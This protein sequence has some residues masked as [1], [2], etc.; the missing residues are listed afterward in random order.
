MKFEF[1]KYTEVTDL[2]FEI[3]PQY[4]SDKYIRFFICPDVFDT[5]FVRILKG[6]DKNYEINEC[7]YLLERNSIPNDYKGQA[8]T[9]ERVKKIIKNDDGSN[10]D[11]YQDNSLDKLIDDL[12]EG[13]GINNLKK[14]NE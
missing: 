14:T 2:A 4:K 6:Y 5:W 12:D 10:W 8:L 11:I 9:I 7:S 3:N 1:G 13:F